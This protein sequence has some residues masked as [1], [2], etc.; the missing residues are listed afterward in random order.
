VDESSAQDFPIRLSARYASDEALI[1]DL[2]RVALALE[3]QSL[4]REEYGRHGAYDPSTIHRRLGSWTA[5]LGQAGLGSG[6]PD[7]GR[8]EEEWMRTILEKWVDLGKQPSYGDMRGSGFSPEGY[9]A[10]YGSWGA[11]L[12]RFA[13]WVQSEPMQPAFASAEVPPRSDRRARKPSIRMRYRVL[14]RDAFSCCACGRSPAT[15]R[16]IVL[17]VDHVVPYSRGGDTTEANLQTLCDRCNL[18]KSDSVQ[19]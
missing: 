13:Q 7:L 17:H 10:R 16:G 15:E 5:A 4:T 12:K 8:T 18:G 3:Q 1:E 19:A 2:R 9:G 11:A 6:R 14:L